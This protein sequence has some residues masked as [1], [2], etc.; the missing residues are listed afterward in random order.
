MAHARGMALGGRGQIFHAVVDHLHRMA[1]LHGQ[2][3]RVAG[4]HGRIILLAAE[5]AAG[6]GLDHAHFVFGQVEDREQRLDAR[7][8]GTAASPRP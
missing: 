6:F 2:Q 7:S 5:G 8:T 1:A 3:S 4:E